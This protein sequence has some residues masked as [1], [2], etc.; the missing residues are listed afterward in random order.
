M[1]PIK[2]PWCASDSVARISRLPPADPDQYAYY[3][4]FYRYKCNNCG[5]QGPEFRNNELAAWDAFNNKQE[6]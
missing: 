6:G 5:K 1:I 3:D 2:C 4:V